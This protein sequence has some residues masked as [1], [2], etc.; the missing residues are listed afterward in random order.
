M[1][2]A[3]PLISAFSYTIIKVHWAPFGRGSR[4]PS[5]KE[6]YYP[7]L[8]KGE[9]RAGVKSVPEPKEKRRDTR[10]ATQQ[11]KGGPKTAVKVAIL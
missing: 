3:N 2:Q 6:H 9:N 5:P 7:G 10:P 4:S 8:R 11:R 1:K